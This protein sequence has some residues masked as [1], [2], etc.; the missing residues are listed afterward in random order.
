VKFEAREGACEVAAITIAHVGF[1]RST[2]VR[3]SG[4]HFLRALDPCDTLPK[5]EIVYAS[6]KQV[7]S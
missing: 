4:G 7:F 6:V 2:P 3:V 5:S 1:G